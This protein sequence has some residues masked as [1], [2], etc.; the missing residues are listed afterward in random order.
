MGQPEELSAMA[1]NEPEQP[2]EEYSCDWSNPNAN[3]TEI[4]AWSYGMG[5]IENGQNDPAFHNYCADPTGMAAFLSDFA[6]EQDFQRPME[7]PR[8]APSGKM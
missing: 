6:K 7:P 4:G 1:D 2:Q 5:W 8:G 3:P